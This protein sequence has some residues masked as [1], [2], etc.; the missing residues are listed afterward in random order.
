MT[1][2]KLRQQAGLTQQELADALGVTQKTISIWE[3]EAL[4][5]S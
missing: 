4:N 1:L 3:R 5:P 2:L